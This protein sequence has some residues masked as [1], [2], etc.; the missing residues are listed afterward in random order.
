MEAVT[1]MAQRDTRELISLAA[2]GDE[3]ALR[4]IIAEHHEDIVGVSTQLTVEIPRECA[5]AV[6]N[7]KRPSICHHPGGNLKGHS[8]TPRTSL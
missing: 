4:R 3:Y 5:A 8:V 7:L 6:S 2:A 1:R